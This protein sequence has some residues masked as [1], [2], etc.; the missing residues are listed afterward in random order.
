M[1]FILAI[2]PL[3]RLLDAATEQ[4]VLQPVHHRAAT[5]RISMYADDAAIFLNPDREK[6]QAIQQILDAFGS[7]SGLRINLSKCAI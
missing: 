7:A 4:R 6:V 5:T 1:L 3:Q 2:D